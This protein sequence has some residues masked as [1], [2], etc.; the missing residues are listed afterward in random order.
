MPI[1]DVSL[2]PGRTTEQIQ[3]LARAITS[4]T[5]EALQI[6]PERVR[7]LMREVPDTHWA[8][9]GHTIAEEKA[10]RPAG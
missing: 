3:G 2:S 1:I 4:A 6:A 10:D 7:V 8:T 9:A 5:S